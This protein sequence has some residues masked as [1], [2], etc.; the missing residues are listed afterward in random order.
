MGTEFPSV[1]PRD[2]QWQWQHS[3]KSVLNALK[4]TLKNGYTGTPLVVQG[5]RLHAPSA[6]VPGLI[7]GQRTRR[8]QRH[9]TPVLLPGKSHGQGSLVGCSPCGH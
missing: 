3:T 9:P 7:P 1:N 8:R 6:A 4:C 2:A 5:L